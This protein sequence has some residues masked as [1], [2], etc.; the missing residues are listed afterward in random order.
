L[1]S[2]EI[3]DKATPEN[4]TIWFGR[5]GTWTPNCRLEPKE[6]VSTTI[7]RDNGFRHNTSVIATAIPQREFF[8]LFV[9]NFCCD[10]YVFTFRVALFSFECL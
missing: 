3:D 10:E 6:V 1:S 5:F 8:R 2:G 9:N 4:K 7:Y